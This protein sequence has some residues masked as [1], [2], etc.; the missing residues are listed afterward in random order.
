MVIQCNKEGH[1]RLSILL[2]LVVIGQNLWFMAYYANIK[3]GGG[4]SHEATPE[5]SR[6][7]NCSAQLGALQK[8]NEE[9]RTKLAK[10][11]KGDRIS[12]ILAE[13]TR[14]KKLSDE[15]EEQSSRIKDQCEEH[16][17]A[18]EAKLGSVNKLTAAKEELLTQKEELLQS[19]FLPVIL[20]GNSEIRS[21]IW[22]K[23]IHLIMQYWKPPHPQRRKVSLCFGF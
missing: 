3:Y 2:G 10:C 4:C 13:N 18:C 6:Q 21:I 23:E 7:W 11:I 16:K 9:M 12:E 1:K 22:T 17:H 15:L 20:K 5:E 14:L 8:A 19:L